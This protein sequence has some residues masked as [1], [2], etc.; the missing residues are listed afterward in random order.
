M[1]TQFYSA[2]QLRNNLGEILNLVYYK[3]QEVIVKK[4]G[5]PVARILPFMEKMEKK[6]P[7]FDINKLYGSFKTKKKFT[8]NRME[9]I[10]KFGF[11]QSAL[12]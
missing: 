8:I 12:K 11:A 1:A 10:A 6:I 4:M 7:L 9:K 3:K 5:K 2:Y